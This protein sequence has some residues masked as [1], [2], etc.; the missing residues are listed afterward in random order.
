MPILHHEFLY[1][2]FHPLI[3]DTIIALEK[4][5][6]PLDSELISLTTTNESFYAKL[7]RKIENLKDIDRLKR[8]SELIGVE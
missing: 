5:Y 6:Y 4:N 2:C 7:I 8:F 1:A 3:P